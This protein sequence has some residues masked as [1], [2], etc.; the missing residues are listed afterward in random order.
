MMSKLVTLRWTSLQASR[1][2]ANLR[3]VECLSSSLRVPE[4]SDAKSDKTCDR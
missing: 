2:R 3:R 1:E 4:S